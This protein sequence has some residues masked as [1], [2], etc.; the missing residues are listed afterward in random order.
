MDV[1]WKQTEIV[2]NFRFELH[3]KAEK[4]KLWSLK[5]TVIYKQF[6]SVTCYTVGNGQNLVGIY[7]SLSSR[8]EFWKKN[9][10]NPLKRAIENNLL[11][12]LLSFSS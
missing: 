12:G 1:I 6:P 8:N 11:S 2:Q 10:L 5:D 3:R 7:I 4:V 9:C